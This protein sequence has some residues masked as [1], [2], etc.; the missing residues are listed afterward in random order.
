MN[1]GQGRYSEKCRNAQTDCSPGLSHDSSQALQWTS[2]PHG[3]QYQREYDKRE[4]K[5]RHS[6]KGQPPD[7]LIACPTPQY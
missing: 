6:A 2:M 5:R 7:S 1:P 4:Q 3:C